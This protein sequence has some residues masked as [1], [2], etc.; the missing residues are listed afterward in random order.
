MA[1]F[2]VP[3]GGPLQPL[4]IAQLALAGFKPPPPYG[5][6]MP[7]M[8]GMPGMPGMPQGQVPGFSVQ[9]GIAKL[10]AGGLAALKGMIGGVTPSGPKGSGP[11]GAYTQADAMAMYNAA[12]AAGISPAGPQG[13]GAGGAYTTGDAMSMFNGAN[14]GASSG[15]GVDFLTGL[16]QQ[17]GLSGGAGAAGGGLGDAAGSVGAFFP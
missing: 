5:V 2:N 14:G 7:G 4:N 13:T 11:G 12:N 1:G 6:S 16:L 15:G 10:G 8:S 9:D 17:L 3:T